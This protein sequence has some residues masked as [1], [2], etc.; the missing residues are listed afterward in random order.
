M[1]ARIDCYKT[2]AFQQAV[3]LCLD[4]EEDLTADE[5]VCVKTALMIGADMMPSALAVRIAC[6]WHRVQDADA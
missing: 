6:I 2:F 1:I 4:D 5:R 3:F